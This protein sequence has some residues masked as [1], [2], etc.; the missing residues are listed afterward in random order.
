MD[1]SIL[2]LIVF[3]AVTAAT[4]AV[5]M[6]IRDLTA[7]PQIAGGRH[8]DGRVGPLRRMPNVFDELPAKSL[9]GRLDQGFDRL[10]LESGFDFSPLTGFLLMIACGLLVGGALSTYYD[11]LLA[12]IAGAMLAM[13]ATLIAFAIFRYR[14]QNAI[15]EQLPHM[16]ELLARAVRAGESVDQAIELV[17]SEGGGVLGKEF[18][19][20]SRQLEMGRSLDTVMKSLATRISLVEL[21]IFS[22]TLV[23]H[24]QTGGNLA[25]TLERMSNVVR[26]RLTARRQMRAATGAARSSTMLIAVVSPLAY[27]I[28]F[29][30]Q[31]EHVGTLYRDPLGMTLLATACVLE[32]VGIIWVLSLMRQEL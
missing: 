1:I 29:A 27:L 9:T 17:G 7:E 6:L 18:A 30:W 28:M 12:G 15:L 8:T 32:V 11:S 23:V 25:D 5:M 2:S 24:R 22:T 20:C 21:R 31:P 19:R 16:L 10:V 4:V 14:R 26:D 13:T 3:A